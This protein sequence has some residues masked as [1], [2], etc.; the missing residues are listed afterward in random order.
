MVKR[1]SLDDALTPEEA[2]FV[3]TGKP[4]KTKTTYQKPNPKPKKEPSPMSRTATKEDFTPETSPAATNPAHYSLPGTGAINARIDP[5]IATALLRA[6]ME[7]RI[8]RQT[9]ST[10]R[11]IIAEALSEW[12]KKHG[13]SPR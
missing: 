3:K 1:R 11:D 8:Q 12:L 10:Q 13:F 6:S 7:R 5:E 2:A 9:P 4:A